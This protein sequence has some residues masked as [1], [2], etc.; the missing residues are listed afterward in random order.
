MGEGADVAVTGK[1]VRFPVVGPSASGRTTMWS[2]ETVEGGVVLGY[3]KWYGPWR[4]YA[5][6]PEAATLYER[7]CLRD[8]ADFCEAESKA[9]LSRAR[10]RRAS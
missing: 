7:R 4:C 1:W 3:V 2:V 6:Y 8:I 9:Q 10:S 5:F